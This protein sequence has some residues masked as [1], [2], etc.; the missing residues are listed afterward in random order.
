MQLWLLVS[1]RGINHENFK[2]RSPWPI[3]WYFMSL[4]WHFHEILKIAISHEPMITCKSNCIYI[5]LRWSCFKFVKIRSLWP[6]FTICQGN[7][8]LTHFWLLLQNGYLWFNP[9]TYRDT[10][11]DI[12]SPWPIFWYLMSLQWHFHEILE[13]AITHLPTI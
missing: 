3:F 12:L 4:Q 8:Y 11:W 6:T 7:V 13:I 1:S 9:N 10:F 5:V 2:S